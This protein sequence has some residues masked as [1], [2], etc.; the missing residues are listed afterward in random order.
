MSID[1]L[2]ILAAVLPLIALPLIIPRVILMA[3]RKRMTDA[4]NERKLQKE[5]VAVMGGMVIVSVVCITLIIINLFYDIS[6]LFPIICIMLVMYTFGMLDDIIGLSWQ[7]KM[8][9]QIFSILLLFL[10]GAYGVQSL[11][12]LFGLDTIPYWASFVLTVFL[13]LLFINGVNFVDGIDGLSSILGLL[14]ASVMAFWC[15]FHGFVDQALISLVMAGTLLAFFAYNVFSK[16]YKIYMGDSGSLVLG[17]FVFISASPAPYNTLDDSFLVDRYFISFM[18]ALC[19]NIL[20]D[21]LRVALFR[22]FRGKSPFHP[23]RTHLHHA[24]VDMGMSHLLATLSI[25]FR[26]LMVLAVWLVTAMAEIQVTLQFFLVFLAGVFFIWYPYFRIDYLRNHQKEKYAK[27]V[28]FIQCLS[29][30]LDPFIHV[31]TRVLDGRKVAN[32]S[33]ETV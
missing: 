25:L 13:G 19:S 24:L 18:M 10:S 26:N 8:I 30:R 3:R 17:L 32:S 31:M 14:V 9:L 21:L 11:C 2:Y 4:P 28:H 5:P 7:F 1:L 15:L 20:F 12:G 29:A 22:V 16:K 27:C 6:T 33:S 23:D